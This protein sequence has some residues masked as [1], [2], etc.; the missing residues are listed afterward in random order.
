M[1][2]FKGIQTSSIIMQGLLGPIELLKPEAKANLCL[3]T[4]NAKNSS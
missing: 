4:N 2:D 3:Y 1:N